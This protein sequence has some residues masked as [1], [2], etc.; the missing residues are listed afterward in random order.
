MRLST[1]LLA[2]AGVVWVLALGGPEAAA[3]SEPEDFA[4]FGDSDPTVQSH[5]DISLEDYLKEAGDDAK[6]VAHGKLRIDGVSMSCGSH[7]T[8]MDPNFQSWGGAYPGFVILNPEWLKG[9]AAPVKLYVYA[10]E[11]GHQYVGRD[12]E[13]ADCFAVKRGRRYGWLEEEGMEAI[14]AFIGKLKGDSEHFGGS[15]RC[16]IMRRCYADAAPRAERSEVGVPR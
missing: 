8:V 12:E 5:L 16:E 13:D 3:Q 1:G 10:H 15:K 9:L 11:C 4:R 2:A 6:L 14:C 7:P